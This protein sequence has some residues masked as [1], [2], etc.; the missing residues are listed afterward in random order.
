MILLPLAK[1]SLLITFAWIVWIFICIL[2]IF[3]ILIQKSKGGGLSSAF[4]GGGAGGVLGTKSADFMTKLT[5]GLVFVFLGLSV[6][7]VKFGAPKPD[8]GTGQSGVPTTQGASA[9]APD[10]GGDSAG[11]A[12]A[13]GTQPAQ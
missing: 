7:L 13:G 1:M 10:A 3:L 2:M 5:I 4:G 6:V 8:L 9:P 12:P 11:T